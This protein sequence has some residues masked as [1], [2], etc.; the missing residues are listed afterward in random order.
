VVGDL[1][2]GPEA[3]AG[4]EALNV[5]LGA[6][7][8]GKPV[9][10][11]ARE[12]EGMAARLASQVARGEEGKGE[13]SG[14]PQDG[15]G[16]PEAAGGGSGVSGGEDGDKAPEGREEA[17]PSVTEEAPDESR[18]LLLAGAEEGFKLGKL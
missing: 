3:E 4:L 10:E 18:R 17:E 7:N 2:E 9:A 12:A 1:D 15:P 5:A 11:L 14:G 8:R 16:Y 6:Y 13:A